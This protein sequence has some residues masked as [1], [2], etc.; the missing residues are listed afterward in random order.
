MIAIN[1]KI[2]DHQ[3]KLDTAKE[4]VKVLQGK[5]EKLLLEKDKLLL[6]EYLPIIQSINMTPE[7]LQA[8]FGTE[9]KENEV[10]NDPITNQY[11]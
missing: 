6:S 3:I 10:Q 7:E 1:Q 11:E 8:F 2:A 5:Q 9:N 4:K